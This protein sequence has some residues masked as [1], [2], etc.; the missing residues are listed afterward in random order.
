MSDVL[1]LGNG[2]N[3][4]FNGDSWDKLIE[5]ISNKYESGLTVDDVK[6]LPFTM[7]VVALSEDKVDKAMHFISKDMNFV[8]SDEQTVFLKRICELPFDSIITANYTFELEQISGV[9]PTLYNYRK[10][11]KYTNG[12]TG[13]KDRFGLHRYYQPDNLNKKIWHIHGDITAPSTV[14]MG[15]YYYGK[16]LSEIQVYTS[17]FIK[18]YKTLKKRGMDC[19]E[20]SWVDS[21]LTN[22]VHILGFGIDYSEVDIWWLICCKKRNFPNTQI[23]YYEPKEKITTA[24]NYLLKSYG[25]KVIDDTPFDGDYRSFYDKVIDKIKSEIQMEE[26]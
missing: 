13:K 18:K 21:F 5:K 8:I 4:T 26:K 24:K 11:R 10:I 7:K 14:I 15:N 12:L 20:Q 2:I 19:P 16:L 25:V 9:K 17:K 3:R 6:E 23:Y 1:F 22:N